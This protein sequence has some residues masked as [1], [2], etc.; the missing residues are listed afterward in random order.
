M[1]NQDFN[2]KKYIIVTKFA[3]ESKNINYIR[4]RIN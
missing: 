2:T 4:I 1:G 3:F